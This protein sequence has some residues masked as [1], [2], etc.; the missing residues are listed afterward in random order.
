MGS[1]LHLTP[2]AATT[3][4]DSGPSVKSSDYFSLRYMHVFVRLNGDIPLRM[5]LGVLDY[6]GHDPFGNAPLGLE[7]QQALS[8]Y[9]GGIPLG[10]FEIL[11]RLDDHFQ[12]VGPFERLVQ[13]RLPA[14]D[15]PSRKHR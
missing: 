4:I 6:C 15:T 14:R 1:D 10:P 12:F 9:A 8:A 5:R 2:Q 7:E 11:L 3:A 13:G